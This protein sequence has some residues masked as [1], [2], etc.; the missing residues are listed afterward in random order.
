MEFFKVTR[1]IIP[2]LTVGMVSGISADTF[3]VNDL[4]DAVDMLPG[5]GICQTIIPAQ[6]TVRAS[7]QESN[8]LPGPDNVSIPSGNYVL[9][10][11]QLSITDD[12]TVTGAGADTTIIDGGGISRVLNIENPPAFPRITVTVDKV[13]IQNGGEIGSIVAAIQVDFASTLNLIDSVVTNN[14]GTD[15]NGIAVNVDGIL[16]VTNST[17]SHNNPFGIRNLGNLTVRG[18]TFFG[19]EERAI[20]SSSDFD[21]ATIINSTLSGNGIDIVNSFGPIAIVNSTLTDGI[22]NVGGPIV[23]VVMLKNTVVTGGCV[24]A[25]MSVGHNL[26][27]DDTCGF[28]SPG[29]L[30][31][32]DPLLGPLQNNGGLT[33][34]HALLPGSPAI[35]A[36]PENCTDFEVNPLSIDQRGAPRP[37]DG[38]GDGIT[39]CDI[40]AFEVQ[41]VVLTV[42]IDIKPGNDVNPVNPRSKGV[43]KVAILT[44]E[45][46]DASKVDPHTV[47]FGAGAAEPVGYRLKDFD[48]DGD[49]DLVLKFR[50]RE[51]EIACGDA[52]AALTGQT[53]NGVRITGTDSVKTV[54]CKQK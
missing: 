18:S 49:Y 44:T 37:V 11:G 15:A 25:I 34:T 27:N 22:V 42:D 24:G 32:T 7:I 2:L 50:T 30:T 53:F 5:D 33:E 20:S 52:E 12:L 40:G 31:N 14:S 54:G 48:S 36:A 51:T 13:T 29:D 10:L 47:R 35:D 26:S 16:N 23:G 41:L 39:A 45:N 38:N 46:F 9:S 4:G 19:N 28:T 6:C 3:T 43:L 1:L 17:I 21:Q 8:A